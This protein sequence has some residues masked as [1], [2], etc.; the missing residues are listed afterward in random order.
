M[1]KA[2]TNLALRR[3]T[4][5]QSSLVDEQSV[6]VVD[7]VVVETII[8]VVQVDLD[9]FAPLNRMMEYSFDSISFLAISSYFD[10]FVIVFV[11]DDFDVD[12]ADC[13]IDRWRPQ[14]RR[15]RQRWFPI[16]D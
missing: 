9:L 13:S 16:F 11:F 15:Q 14:P 2:Q 12:V 3:M 4:T 7:V 6:N 5:R 1:K 8:I 10:R